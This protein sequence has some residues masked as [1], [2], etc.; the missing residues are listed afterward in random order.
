MYAPTPDER[1]YVLGIGSSTEANNGEIVEA[2]SGTAG[3]QI[4]AFE[5]TSSV[6]STTPDGE[7]SAWDRRF[8]H[9]A[10]NRVLQQRGI[11]GDWG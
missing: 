9:L 6:M 7:A 8:G 3:L 4:K 10:A 2:N 1:Y 5:F 11:Y